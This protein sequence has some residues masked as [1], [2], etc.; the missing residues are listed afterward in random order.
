M[1]DGRRA[2]DDARGSGSA[3]RL[4]S[5]RSACADRPAELVVELDGQV[6]D[7]LVGQVGGDVDLARRTMPMVITAARASG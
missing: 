4:P 7:A 2:L 6:G 3:R 5:S 1:R